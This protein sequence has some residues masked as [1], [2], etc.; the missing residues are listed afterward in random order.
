[1][2]H[3][4]TTIRTSPI[5]LPGPC[6]TGW[7]H[8]FP[9]SSSN[10]PRSPLIRNC[11]QSLVS[12]FWTFTPPSNFPCCVWCP[13]FSPQKYDCCRSLRKP[14]R[15]AI[16]ASN[17]PRISR[18]C[19]SFGHQAVTG[20]Y[21]IKPRAARVVDILKH[22]PRPAS[23]QG[24]RFFQRFRPVWSPSKLASYRRTGKAP[25]GGQ[26][27]RCCGGGRRPRP[28]SEGVP[29]YVADMSYIPAPAAGGRGQ[30]TRLRKAAPCAYIPRHLLGRSRSKLG[31]KHAKGRCGGGSLLA[32]GLA[33]PGGGRPRLP[34]GV[35]G[36]RPLCVPWCRK[37]V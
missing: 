13:P 4:L 31:R 10:P 35:E 3:C 25:Q 17:S 30:A 22:P 5:F 18:R 27:K 20:V 14:Y 6:T 19:T 29:R 23:T 21:I 28:L 9:P 26:G 24:W 33:R 2:R 8:T 1:V 7:V 12:N 32:A 37:H 34:S 11:T 16:F 36:C 15:F